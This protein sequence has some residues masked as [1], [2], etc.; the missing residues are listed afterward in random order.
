V[1]GTRTLTRP[2]RWW[3][4]FAVGAV[5][6]LAGTIALYVEDPSVVSPASVADLLVSLFFLVPLLGYAFRRR[7][8]SR[9]LWKTTVPFAPLWDVVYPTLLLPDRPPV[10][11]PTIV[12]FVAVLFVVMAIVK[13]V[14][15]LRYAYLSSDLWTAG[16]VA[17]ANSG[18][19]HL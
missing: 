6:W 16:I 5:L 7:F 4:A 10:A 17:A 12:T 18:S 3:K 9:K 13:Y 8:L 19:Q 15:L 11:S 14:A 2:G 1:E